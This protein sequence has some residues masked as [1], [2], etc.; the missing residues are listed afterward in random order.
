L[1]WDLFDACCRQRGLDDASLGAYL[2]RRAADPA[3]V[4]TRVLAQLDDGDEYRQ[5]FAALP[6]PNRY[7]DGLENAPRI[8]CSGAILG[9]SLHLLFNRDRAGRDDSVRFG[10]LWNLIQAYFDD[11][12][13]EYD[14]LEAP[15]ARRV[16]AGR[17][18]YGLAHPPPLDEGVFLPEAGDH[19][20]VR[21]VTS[22]CQ[23]LFRLIVT[24]PGRATRPVIYR[25]L[26][27][28]LIEARRDGLETAPLRLGARV[29]PAMAGPRLSAR[30]LAPLKGTVYG[31]ALASPAAD[32]PPLDDHLIH[33]VADFFR[34]VDDAV[35]LELDV[36]NGTWN[37]ALTDFV[38]ASETVDPRQPRDVADFGDPALREGASR[39]ALDSLFTAYDRLVARIEAV[40]PDRRAVAEVFLH[41]AY[42]HGMTGLRADG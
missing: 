2:E 25:R 36:A 15:L 39:H 28:A 24:L 26:G 4:L 21:F 22:L 11:I 42:V 6:M 1:E 7:C 12:V 18:R 35:D 40:V 9:E 37:S 16:S 33:L 20:L 14:G 23:G 30:S 38:I 19:L 41:M 34:L 29:V 8:A 31:V 10:S 17:I 27:D 5:L 13:D 32:P 3:G